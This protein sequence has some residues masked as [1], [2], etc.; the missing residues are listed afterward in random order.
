MKTTLLALILAL[1]SASAMADW[2][3]GTETD[4]YKISVNATTFRKAGSKAKMWDLKDYKIGQSSISLGVSY[5]SA[6]RQYEYD[7]EEL[8]SRLLALTLYSKPKGGGKVLHSQSGAGD[9]SPVVPDT[10][11]EVLWEIACNK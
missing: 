6:K 4:D 11:G 2:I 9:R 8:Q 1:A 3:F 7:C 5:W 10:I